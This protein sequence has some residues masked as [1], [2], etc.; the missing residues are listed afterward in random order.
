MKFER[1]IDLILNK[2]YKNTLLTFKSN[3]LESKMRKT[4]VGL[5]QNQIFDEKKFVK[6]NEKKNSFSS[7]LSQSTKLSK[8]ASTLRIKQTL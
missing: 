8:L 2:Q 4:K 1:N 5:N 3:I 7:Q 6:L